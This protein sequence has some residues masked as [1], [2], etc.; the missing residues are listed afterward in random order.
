MGLRLASP[1]PRIHLPRH[2]GRAQPGGSHGP[3]GRTCS[4][5]HTPGIIRAPSP[6]CT[7]SP[8]RN[9][10]GLSL[11]GSACARGWRSL[12]GRSNRQSVAEVSGW[13]RLTQ[14]T[15]SGYVRSVLARS[16]LQFQSR[17]L[18]RLGTG[19]RD[20]HSPRQDL[21]V[22]QPVHLLP[23]RWRA[24]GA[25]PCCSAQGAPSHV[26]QGPLK[27]GAAR[28]LPCPPFAAGTSVASAE[29]RPGSCCCPRPTPQ[30]PS[31]S[32]PVRAARGT[33]RSQV[34]GWPLV[35][36]SPGGALPSP[37]SLERC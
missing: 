34:R 1:S 25:Q 6:P 10:A 15:A 16:A 13:S 27:A 14:A 37:T 17:S 18:W 5:A 33:T 29:P 35:T 12:Y 20:R 26:G 24:A 7:P 2:M 36:R 28:G 23:G 4:P 21:G 19:G 22:G 32:G 9:S 31:S 11:T 3:A 8:H 30:G